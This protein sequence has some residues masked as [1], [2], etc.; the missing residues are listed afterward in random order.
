MARSMHCL[1][2]GRV[3][4]VFFRAF[5]ADQAARLGLTGWTRN[6]PGGQVEVLV[7]GA[8]EA[9]ETMAALLAKGP[10]LARVDTVDTVFSDNEPTHS[11][12]QIRR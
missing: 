6:L 3:Q 2:N 12:F 10:L 11:E 8:D 4:G 9:L 1:V 7:Q 5:V